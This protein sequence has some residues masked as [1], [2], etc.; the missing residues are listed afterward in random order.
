MKVRK[1]V[2]YC[3]DYHKVNSKEN[4]LRSYGFVLSK[5]SMT[6]Y[7]KDLEEISSEE[8]FDFLTQMNE[9]TKQSTKRSR[10]ALLT[11][12]FTFTINSLCPDL[13]NPCDSQMLKKVFRPPKLKSWTILDKE[14]VDEII[15][16]TTNRRNRLILELMARGG[17]RI[18]EVLKLTPGDIEERKL[19]LRHPKSGKEE[20]AVFIPQKVALRLKE[21][22]AEKEI[23][24]SQ[25]IFPIGYSA[26]RLAVK[27][28]G[29]LVDIDL[30]PHDLR[31]HAATYASRSGTPIEIVSKVILRHANLSTT[32]LYL[33]KVSDVEAIRWIENLYSA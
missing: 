15:F 10:Y 29:K 26:A 1:A 14:V 4:T 9:G 33:G 13:K 21:Y 32:Q 22:V 20:E 30:R 3:L 5:F 17:L 25:R 2:E 19:I 23:G 18:G 24:E 12:F 6:F 11:A 8:V 28:A 7:G 31:R 27:K 16:R